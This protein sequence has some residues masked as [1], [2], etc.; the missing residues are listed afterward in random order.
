[1]KVITVRPPWAHAIIHGGKDV[2]NR[3]WSTKYRGSL[4]IHAGL[5]VHKNVTSP[6]GVLLERG[7]LGAIIGTVELVD[8][9]EDSS[10]KWANHPEL[11]RYH[12]VLANPRPV[13][14]IPHSGRLGLS[15]LNDDVASQVFIGL[16]INVLVNSGHY[17]PEE[18]RRSAERAVRAF[19]LVEPKREGTD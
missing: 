7:A 15:H 18:A 13:E 12:W 10:S 19:G 3:S 4:A 5:T 16:A 9:V 2:E 1:M 14:P 8:V 11:A 6:A 17:T